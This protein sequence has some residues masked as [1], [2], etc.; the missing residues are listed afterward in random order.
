[1]KK[2]FLYDQDRALLIFLLLINL[3]ED[4]IIYVTYKNNL[5]KIKSLKGQKIILDENKLKFRKIFQLCIDIKKFR[6]KYG[7]LLRGIKEK[8]I[9]LYGIPFFE[10]AQRFFYKE[11]IIAIEEG[12]SIYSK[13]CITIKMKIKSL[14]ISILSVLFCLK[15]RKYFEN[16]KIKKLY[17]TKNLYRET[18]NFKYNSEVVDLKELWDQ[19]TEKEK[20]IILNIFK[21]NNNILKKLEKDTII[22]LTQPLSEDGVIS[23]ERKIEIYS[24]ILNKYSGDSILI[25]PH[26]REITDYEKAFPNYYIIKE[27]YPIEILELL[28]VKIKKVVTLFSTAAFGLGRNLEIDF[29]GTEVDEKLYDRFG[30][31]DNIMKRNAFL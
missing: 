26:P 27:K 21:F 2:V 19:K 18:T 20:R 14:L 25:K 8:K 5:N 17:L 3:L 22:L 16:L 28:G 9:E 13:S 31:C 6:K 24:E 4:E 7:N 15:E 29:Y 11:E 30:N 1:M 12:V 23:E 10:L